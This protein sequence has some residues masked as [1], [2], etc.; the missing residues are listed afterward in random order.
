[1]SAV[2][3]QK[4]VRMRAL[5]DQASETRLDLGALGAPAPERTTAGGGVRNA[6]GQATGYGRELSSL[7]GWWLSVD[8]GLTCLAIGLIGSTWPVTVVRWNG[9]VLGLWLL[10]FAVC[11]CAGAG[12]RPLPRAI[13]TA[14]LAG[15]L[16]AA[17]VGAYCVRSGGNPGDTLAVVALALAVLAATNGASAAR[18]GWRSWY[19][20]RAALALLASQVVAGSVHMG[21][22]PAVALSAMAIASGV[23]ETASGAQEGLLRSTYSRQLE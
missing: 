5:Q 10:A 2:G 18:Y 16:A 3:H 13:R 4:A 1:M 7:F 11:H 22:V 14:S 19:A 15:G 23:L 12:A 6:R 20:V 9:I 17:V 8:F 21:A